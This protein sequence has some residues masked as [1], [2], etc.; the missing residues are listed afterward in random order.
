VNLGPQSES[1]SKKRIFSLASKQLRVERYGVA[2]IS[3]LLTNIRLFCRIWSLSQGSFVK[4]TCV[5]REPTDR[6]HLTVSDR[7][8]IFKREMKERNEKEK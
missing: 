6:S 5:F 3:R 2:D 4:E 7:T 1:L 8:M